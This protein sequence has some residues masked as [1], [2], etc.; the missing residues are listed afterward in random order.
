LRNRIVLLALLLAPALPAMEMGDGAQVLELHFG[1]DVNFS[2]RFGD[3]GAP[4]AFSLGVVDTMIHGRLSREFSVL[5]EIAYEASGEGFGFDVERL[6]LNYEPRS[7]FRVSAGR[8]HTPLGY[9]NTAYHHARWMYA[10]TEAPLLA[11]FEDEAGPLPAHTIG[12]LVHGSLPFPGPLRFEYDLAV[13]NGR[14]PQSDPPQNFSD[15]NEGKSVCAALHVE[16]K[17]LRLGLS[18]M[19]D[20]STLPGGLDLEERIAMVD[21]HWQFGDLEAIAEGALIH[22]DIEGVTA[23][24]YGGYAQVAWGLWENLHLY[25]RAERFIRDATE[26]YLLTPTASIVVGGV[27]YEL[28]PTAALKLEGGWE[29][30][31]GVEGSTARGQLSWLF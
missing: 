8:F 24:N 19:L 5:A 22:H 31:A 26:S 17:G 13:G 18:G 21:L 29:R 28:A 11:R 1:G 20:N 30:I 14:G 4:S 23:L 25:G 15:V 12:V 3:S 10:T 6:M 16:L 2:K 7:W 9:W 27:R